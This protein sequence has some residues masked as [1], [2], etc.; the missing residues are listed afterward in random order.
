MVNLPAAIVFIVVVVAFLLATSRQ[1][2]KE[3]YSPVKVT[4]HYSP[5]TKS[6]TVILEVQE[7]M[8]INIT[9][10]MI[11]TQPTHDLVKYISKSMLND[12]QKTVELQLMQIIEESKPAQKVP[13]SFS[14]AIAP[15]YNKFAV[16]YSKIY[17][18]DFKSSSYGLTPAEMMQAFEYAVDADNAIGKSHIVQEL[19]KVCSG[20][21]EVVQCP[22]EGCKR[23]GKLHIIIPHLNDGVDPHAWN[24]EDI[25]DWLETLDID[26][27][28]KEEVNDEQ[29]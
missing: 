12:I 3:M 14:S 26:I 25:A 18:Y 19:E 9:D 5:A 2:D 28:I 15:D 8:A 10:E 7:K 29:D 16:D 17:E 22:V 23:E 6:F 21:D 27:K 1:K 4:Q 13:Y 11:L 20:L 24:R